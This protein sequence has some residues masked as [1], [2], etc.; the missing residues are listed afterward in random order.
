M[1]RNLKELELEIVLKKYDE[2]LNDNRNLSYFLEQYRLENN[3][4]KKNIEIL[5]EVYPIKINEVSNSSS[6]I[7]L[8]YGELEKLCK[9]YKE[10][11]NKISDIINYEYDFYDDITNIRND[12]DKLL[13]EVE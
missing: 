4:L 7:L 10:V 3:D 9:K 13:K 8:P 6:D 1:D 12:I 2:I 11:I 5:K